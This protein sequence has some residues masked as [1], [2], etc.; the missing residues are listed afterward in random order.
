MTDD[1]R[2][3]LLKRMGLAVT[4]AATFVYGPAEIRRDVDPVVQLDRERGVDP[5]PSRPEPTL[6]ER[7][8]SYQNL[9]RGTAE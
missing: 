5:G 3:S 7:Q 6:S 4:R 9:P 8:Q 1:Q 2:P